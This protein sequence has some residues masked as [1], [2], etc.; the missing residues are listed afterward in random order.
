MSNTSNTPNIQNVI[1]VSSPLSNQ[2]LLTAPNLPKPLLQANPKH[3]QPV[4]LT[5]VGTLPPINLVTTPVATLLPQNQTPT[6]TAS[7]N[8]TNVNASSSYGGF[9]KQKN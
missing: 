6:S 3:L 1:Q 7:P 4:P 2:L 9:G 5:Q 8:S